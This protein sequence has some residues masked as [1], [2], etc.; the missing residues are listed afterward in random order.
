VPITDTVAALAE[1]R[2][3]LKGAMDT[4]LARPLKEE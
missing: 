4:L 3:T 2:L 1:G